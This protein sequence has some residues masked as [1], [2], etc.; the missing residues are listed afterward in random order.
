LLALVVGGCRGAPPT[1]PPLAKGPLYDAAFYRNAY[2]DA[3]E[4][5]A[6][7]TVYRIDPARSLLRVEVRRSGWLRVLGHH[8][9]LENRTIEGFVWI[10]PARRRGRADARVEVAGFEVDPVDARHPGD[11]LG[12]QPGE[13]AI[14]GTRSNLLGPAGLDA[15]AHPTL[16]G[17][18]HFL[19]WSAHDVGRFSLS[20]QVK[21]RIWEGEVEARVVEHGQTVSVD[22]DWTLSQRAVGLEPIGVFAGAISVADRLGV[23]LRLQADRVAPETEHSP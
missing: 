18:V 13:A 20:L 12:P 17:Q 5:V 3:D 14:A 16:T 21:D 23:R 22:L 10:G 2:R 8:H 15:Q 19:D 7:G 6:P 4:K 1:P 11:D 9:V